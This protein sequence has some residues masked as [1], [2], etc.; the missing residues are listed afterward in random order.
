MNPTI[1]LVHGAFAESAS[2]DPVI[3]RLLDADQSVI[4][5]ANPLRGLASDAESVR[6][7]C[8]RSTDR[9]CW[10]ATPTAAR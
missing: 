9:C 1:V 2:W 5:A 8:A 7:W 6:T 10:S 3:E 4:A